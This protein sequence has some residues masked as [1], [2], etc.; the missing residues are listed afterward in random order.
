MQRDAV[1][2]SVVVLPFTILVRSQR[3]RESFVEAFAMTDLC[4][5]FC[6][7]PSTVGKPTE[8][9]FRI[10]QS[11][12]ISLPDTGSYAKL[13]YDFPLLCCAHQLHCSLHSVMAVLGRPLRDK[14]AMSRLPPWKCFT[15]SLTR[16][17]PM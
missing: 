9:N 13:R 2:C 3:F 1:P 17:A 14:L 11:F 12:I 5:S 4:L 16:L 15:Q 10:S 6:A 8:T 7:L